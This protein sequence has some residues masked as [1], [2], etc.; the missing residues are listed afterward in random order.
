MESGMVLGQN[1]HTNLLLNMYQN[2]LLEKCSKMDDSMT[3]K[4]W[5][6]YQEVMEVYSE[7]GMVIGQKYHNNSLLYLYQNFFLYL[8]QNFFYSIYLNFLMFP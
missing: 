2:F 7:S 8:Y 6:G 4:N 5:K 1:Y 3:T